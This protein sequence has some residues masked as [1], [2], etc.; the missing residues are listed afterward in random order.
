MYSFLS[1]RS[2]KEAWDTFIED[3]GKLDTTFNIPSSPTNS[4]DQWMKV[5]FCRVT[6]VVGSIRLSCSTMLDRVTMPTFPHF[7]MITDKGFFTLK[8]RYAAA[9]FGYLKNFL[10]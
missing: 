5:I 2:N 3:N 1:S 7:V 6:S 8:S 10:F 4:V 9:S